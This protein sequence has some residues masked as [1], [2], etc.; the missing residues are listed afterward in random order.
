M[1]RD[2]GPPSPSARLIVARLRTTRASRLTTFEDL[3]ELHIDDMC[4]IGKAPLRFKAATL[5]LLKQLGKCNMA[6]LDRE[7]LIRFG[8]NE[9]A[10]G[11]GP[12]TL[13]IDIGTIKLALSHAAAGHGFPIRVGPVDREAASDVEREK[14]LGNPHIRYAN[15]TTPSIAFHRRSSSPLDVPVSKSSR[16]ELRTIQQQVENVRFREFLSSD[17]IELRQRAPHD[18]H[19]TVRPVGNGEFNRYAALAVK[20]N[21]V[22]KLARVDKFRIADQISDPMIL[23]MRYKLICG[24]QPSTTA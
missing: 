24:G 9:P 7:Q 1:M 19:I 2:T 22:G 4:D 20:E 12:V 21:F 15:R 14:K 8:R 3:T 23:L 18:G 11:G 17:L 16:S 5:E 6:S 13:G 10:Q